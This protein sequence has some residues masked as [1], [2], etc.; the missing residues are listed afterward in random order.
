MRKGFWEGV[1]KRTKEGKGGSKGKSLLR[2]ERGNVK[3]WLM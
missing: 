1:H 2:K 3:M